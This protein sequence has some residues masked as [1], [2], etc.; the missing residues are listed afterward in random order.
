MQLDEERRQRQVK[1]SY[2]ALALYNLAKSKSD[3]IRKKNASLPE[4]W[5][6]ALI[7][8]LCDNFTQVLKFMRSL[9]CEEEIQNPSCNP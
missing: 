6:S 7:I 4:S 1:L 9:Y 8:H 2:F 5:P 3:A